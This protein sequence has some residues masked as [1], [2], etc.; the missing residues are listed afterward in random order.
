MYTSI[1]DLRSSVRFRKPWIIVF[2]WAT[3]FVNSFSFIDLGLL[4]FFSEAHTDE[5]DAGDANGLSIIPT[6]D[7]D[8][9][10]VE[11]VGGDG[12]LDVDVVVER[13]ALWFIEGEAEKKIH[14]M[15][16]TTSYVLIQFYDTKIVFYSLFLPFF[17]RNTLILSL[18]VTIDCPYT[19]NHTFLT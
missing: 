18:H 4:R 19:P 16:T 13:S 12:S 6:G 14:G 3:A 8:R 17:L 9:L 15:R 5:C 1:L 2:F 11:E 10:F 7:V